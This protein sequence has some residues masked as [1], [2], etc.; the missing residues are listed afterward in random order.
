MSP[1]CNLVVSIGDI[2]TFKV[3]FTPL[4]YIPTIHPLS[5]YIINV[6][7]KRQRKNTRYLKKQGMLWHNLYSSIP[8]LQNSVFNKH[9]EYLKY[10]KAHNREEA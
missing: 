8:R 10:L 6:C 1:P 5:F 7:Y 4:E 3:P 2:L 9:W